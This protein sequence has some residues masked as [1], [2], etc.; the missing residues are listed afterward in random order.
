[1]FKLVS[2]I[3]VL[4]RHGGFVTVVFTILQSSNFTSWLQYHLLFPYSFLNW[5]FPD[6]NLF[7]FLYFWTRYGGVGWRSSA[8]LE[9]PL[10]GCASPLMTR[11]L[12]EP[13]CRC[14]A[15]SI[16]GD[17]HSSLLSLCLSLHLKIF[18]KPTSTHNLNWCCHG[19]YN[20]DSNKQP[21]KSALQ[22]ILSIPAPL[23]KENWLESVATDFWLK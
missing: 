14:L 16:P 9:T 12:Y 20:F 13:W 5:S 15:P 1:M 2:C 3:W 11:S 22:D 6:L 10:L 18:K 8:G 4:S 19:Y 23:P 7:P 17:I 21:V